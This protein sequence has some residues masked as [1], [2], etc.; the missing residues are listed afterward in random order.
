MQ[1]T[2]FYGRKKNQNN[3]EISCK[4]RCL[5]NFGIALINVYVFLFFEHTY[6]FKKNSLH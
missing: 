4:G 2:I 6:N 5:F 1:N 3:A